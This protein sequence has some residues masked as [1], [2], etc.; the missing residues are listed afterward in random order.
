M[1]TLIALICIA[2]ALA[3]G[4][5]WSTRPLA[6]V[7]QYPEYRA[8]AQVVAAE[9]ARVAAEVS[10]R[11]EALPARVGQRFERGAELLRIDD[12]SYRLDVERARNQVELLANRLRLAEAQLAQ[13]RA[14]AAR[15]FLSADA[16]RIK[17]TELA[18]LGSELGAARQALDSA[19]LQLA[20][21]VIRAPYA[22]V[23]G[24]RLASVGDFA[25]PGTPLLV[26]A[27][28]AGAEVHAQVPV[29]LMATLRAAADWQLHAGGE[30]V[31]VTLQRVSPLVST[32]GQMQE[33]VFTAAAALT[34]GLAG[35][36]RWRSTTPHLPP[37]WVQQR[38]GEAGVW[39]LS[40]GRPLFVAL[41]HAEAG[42]AV[43][44]DLPADTALIDAE[45]FSIGLPEAA[46]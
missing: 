44:V 25:A 11:I 13:H 6:E 41:P 10:G 27:A 19:R 5:Q 33:V 38:D 31:A 26:L 1:K 39:V 15:G 9:R 42:R 28:I 22:G 23:V 30:A 20:R 7:V 21:T 3:W 18:V 24:E 12:R 40:A 16:L 36:L 45:R 43:A 2:P 14:L 35:E 32:A 46:Q 4:G 34:P 17:E 29:S 37:A 8:P